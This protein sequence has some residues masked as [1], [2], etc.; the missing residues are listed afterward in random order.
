MDRSEMPSMQNSF[1]NGEHTMH[2]SFPRCVHIGAFIWREGNMLRRET[3]ID[4][5][6]NAPQNAFG[7]AHVNNQYEENMIHTPAHF[8]NQS[9]VHF[10][11]FGLACVGHSIPA[12]ER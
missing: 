6:L 4:Y 10:D 1:S 12:P 3:H 9:A 8:T 5:L 2:T 7:R 11:E